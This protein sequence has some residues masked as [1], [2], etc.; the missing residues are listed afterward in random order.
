M[1]RF[2]AAI[3]MIFAAALASLVEETMP[4]ALSS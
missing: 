1:H 2:F 3:A 4:L